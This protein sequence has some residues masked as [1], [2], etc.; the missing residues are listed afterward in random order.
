VA[1]VMSGPDELTVAERLRS[2]TG[3]FTPAE[4]R[5]AR[6]ILA[7]YPVAGLEP[8]AKLAAASDVSAPTV[9]RLISKLSF[10]SYAEFQQSLKT[11]VG[12]RMSSPLEMHAEL[13]GS[14][15]GGALDRTERVLCEGIQ[16]SFAR[17]PPAEFEQAVRL[18]ADPRRGVLLIGGRFSSML[19]EY[20]AAHLRI[21][22]PG[23]RLVSGA[24]ADRTS[25]L[26]D[27]GPRDVLVAFDYRR[28][29]RDT[30]RLARAAKDQ[31]ATVIAFTDP[32]LSPLSA[33]ADV[34]LTSSVASPS[35][36]DAATP[37]MALVEAL[38]AALVDQMGGAPRERMSRYD[39]LHGGAVDG[40]DGGPAIWP[41]ARQ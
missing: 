25:S 4:R 37:A 16:S 15:R 30:V 11:E 18:L 23:A 17:L 9:L 8:V 31:G 32:Y 3:A 6:R 14:D 10:D 34:I 12:A 40:M 7:D 36:F 26:L 41:E 24:G 20:L 2:Q 22:R 13:P 38:I 19:A 27:I 39:A 35:P 28:Y 29:Q 33:F 5:V 1:V 21:L